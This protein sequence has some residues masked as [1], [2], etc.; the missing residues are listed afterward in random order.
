MINIPE[1]DF[2]I[3]LLIFLRIFSAFVSS[4]VYSNKAVPVL[5][6]VFLSLIISY[7]VFLTIDKSKIVVET[8]LG[9]LF[10]NAMTEIFTG[11][12]I[13][14]M[15]NFVF[16]GISFAGSLIGF[17]MGLS[18][19][20]ALN[21]VDGFSNNVIGNILSMAS[22][23]LFI[24]INGHL[25]VISGLFYSFSIVHIGKNTFT[26]PVYQLLI[27]YSAGIFIIA[28]KIASPF[29][30]SYFLVY[31]A[32]GI[33]ARVIPQMQV[34]FVS[35]P[36]MLGLG[37]ILLTTLVPIYFYVIKYMLSGYEDNL[38]SLIKAMGQ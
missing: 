6:K 13:G 12:V 8:N 5:M 1:L 22:L 38:V 27:R 30:V 10:T 24:L 32:E 17:N 37:F 25:Y 9:W 29:I 15:L 21:P 31:I 16:H 11:L 7:I 28:V 33:M 4:P 20:E 2:I 14:F 23:L 34:F 35:Q 19:A 36:I 26:E 18:M 3:V